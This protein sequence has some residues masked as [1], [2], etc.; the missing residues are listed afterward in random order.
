MQFVAGYFRGQIFS[1]I[2][3]ISTKLPL[4]KYMFNIIIGPPN[5]LENCMQPIAKIRPLKITPIINS[6]AKS[7]I[8]LM[9]LVALPV[10]VTRAINP[11]L[12]E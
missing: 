4:G 11:L 12:Y 7:A 8:R 3:Q 6:I 1:W 9:Q 5:Y 10:L 2:L